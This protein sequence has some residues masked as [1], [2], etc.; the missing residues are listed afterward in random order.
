MKRQKKRQKKKQ[1]IISK[2]LPWIEGLCYFVAFSFHGVWLENISKQDIE[3]IRLFWVIVF[4]C[5]LFLLFRWL[6]RA[7]KWIWVERHVKDSDYMKFYW[8]DDE[9]FTPYMPYRDD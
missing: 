7:Y 5:L 2:L 6:Y 8:E 4:L 1:G 9:D 3:T